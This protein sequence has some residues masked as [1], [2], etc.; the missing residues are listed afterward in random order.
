TVDNAATLLSYT[1]ITSPID[2]RTGIQQ[3]DPGN[4]VHASDANGLVVVTQLQPIDL[5]FSLPQQNLLAINEQLTKQDSLPVYALGSDGKTTIDTGK[6]DLVDTQI[7]QTP[8]TIRLK[9]TFPN[10]GNLLWPGGFVNV[11]LLLDTKHDA[12][13]IPAVAVQRGPQGSY[14]F[15]LK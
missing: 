14:V 3:V 15:A 9:C 5:V 1:T 6:L 2:G 11:R 13:V 7:D 4:I 8:G 12:L 10:K